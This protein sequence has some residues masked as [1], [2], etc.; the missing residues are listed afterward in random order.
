[1]KTPTADNAPLPTPDA[2]IMDAVIGNNP[3]LK[4]ELLAAIDTPIEALQ[5][6]A[7]TAVGL[8]AYLMITEPTSKAAHKDR[9]ALRRAK[10]LFQAFEDQLRRQETTEKLGDLHIHLT[11]DGEVTP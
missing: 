9:M 5:I 2:Y 6:A 8:E 7:N 4:D 3:S 10:Q 1:M 11:P